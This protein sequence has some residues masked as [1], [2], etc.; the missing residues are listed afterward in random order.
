MS[1][2]WTEEDFERH[3]QRVKNGRTAQKAAPKTADPKKALHALGRM[4][5]GVMNK[6]E[7]RFAKFLDAQKMTGAVQ[8]WHFEG[9]KLILA[10]N[11][12]ITFDFALLPEDGVLTLIDVKGSKAIV[13]D[14][15][16]A[17]AKIAADMFPFVFK[18]A[19][20]RPKGDPGGWII[21]D[22]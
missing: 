22:I 15:F 1:M 13:T 3:Q 20:P 16:K 21:E 9:I 8:W 4:K 17:K 2:N 14:D 5:T 6:T 11:T 18:V 19:Y 7:E 12:S 10:P